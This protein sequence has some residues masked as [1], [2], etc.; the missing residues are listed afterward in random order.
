MPLDIPSFQIFCSGKCRSTY[1]NRTKR[2]LP[3]TGYESPY[4][5]PAEKRFWMRV[6]KNGPT[7]VHCSGVGSC[8]IWTGKVDGLGYGVIRDN[9]VQWKVHRYSYTL[10]IGP[11]PSGL[12]ICHKCD[13]PSCVNPNHLWAD[14]HKNNMRDCYNKGRMGAVVNFSVLCGT[15]MDLLSDQQL[16]TIISNC[17]SE[18]VLRGKFDVLST[19]EIIIARNNL[20]NE[21]NR[22]LV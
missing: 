12:E 9:H 15:N 10:N 16:K 2:G 7:P 5:G 20:Q 1:H 17:K 18:C 4:N 13:N 19:E 14:T 6:D 8:W 3:L 22:R 21:T 11:I